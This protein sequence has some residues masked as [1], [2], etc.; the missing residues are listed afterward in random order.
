[1]S[2]N[3]QDEQPDQFG[4]Y[5]E[6]KLAQSLSAAMLQTYNWMGLGLLL[7]AAVAWFS[8]D[9]LLSVLQSFPQALFVAFLIE[10]GIVWWLSARI[11]TLDPE[12]ALAGF[13]GYAAING[14]TMAFVFL[15]YD[16]GS[17]T[18]VFGIT[19]AMFI[20]MSIIGYTTK[21]DLS[22]WGSYLMMGV[23]GVI[24]A[25]VANFWLQSPILYWIVS[26]AGVAI[27]LALTIY[28]TQ[29][30]KNMTI[31]ALNSGDEANL[32]RVGVRGALSLYLD[33]INLFIFL[34]RI[35]G[36]RR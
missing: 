33:F 25:S 16:L 20:A 26:Y 29:K 12:V 22:G 14:F 32:R 13:L 4:Y 30:I 36:R 34:L 31:W 21:M 15:A 7:T 8:Q 24:I 2:F 27:F 3:M 35:L 6:G 9:L 11:M 5:N 19:T 23:I 28:D 17:V 18:L 1:M 10:L